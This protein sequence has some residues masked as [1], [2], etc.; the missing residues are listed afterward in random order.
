MT[1]PTGGG[2]DLSH[3]LGPLPEWAWIA[4]ATGGAVIYY[5]KIR[6]PAGVSLTTTDN[7]IDPNTGL[8]LDSGTNPLGDSGGGVGVGPGG[9]VYAGAPSTP[10][11]TIT[12]NDE[13]YAAAMNDL[14]AKNYEPTLVDQALRVYISDG[15]PS[16]N[17][18]ALINIA[19]KDIGPLP[20][21]LPPVTGG[22]GGPIAPPNP[23]PALPHKTVGK[24]NIKFVTK[25]GLD[26]VFQIAEHYH[27]AQIDVMASNPWMKAYDINHLPHGKIVTIINYKQAF[28]AQHPPPKKKK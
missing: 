25:A 5:T 15:K 6:K 11:N 21:P 26:S 20:E 7:T 3:K 9:W 24:T 13:W 22:G 19:I 4:I 16:I 17:Q 27:W 12:N 14:L 23:W 18:R 10:V 28:P 1:T 8:P 2:L